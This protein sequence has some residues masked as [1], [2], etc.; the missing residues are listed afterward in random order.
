VVA[1][2]RSRTTRC[3]LNSSRR[4]DNIRSL[5]SEDYLSAGKWIVLQTD[6][7]KDGLLGVTSICKL[8]IEIMEQKEIRGHTNTTTVHDKLYELVPM[9]SS[10]EDESGDID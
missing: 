4:L 3:L 7:N 9:E 2:G 5:K 6:I 1:P 10:I 8:I